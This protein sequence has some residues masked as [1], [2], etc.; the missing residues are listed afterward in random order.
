MLDFN[1]MGLTIG[2]RQSRSQRRSCDLIRMADASFTQ[3][4]Y[5]V[6]KFV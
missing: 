5:Q 6:H 1:R 4:V 3:L 2:Q